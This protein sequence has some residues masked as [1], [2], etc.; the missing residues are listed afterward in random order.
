MF[1]ITVQLNDQGIVVLMWHYCDKLKPS[2]YGRDLRFLFF[3]LKRPQ[4]VIHHNKP[5][6]PDVC[7]YYLKSDLTAYWLNRA[8]GLLH[9]RGKTHHEPNWS[10]PAAQLPW[11]RLTLMNSEPTCVRMVPTYVKCST[12]VYVRHVIIFTLP[13]C[14][15]KN[16][17][18]D[19]ALRYY[20]GI[21]FTI[22]DLMRAQPHAMVFNVCRFFSSC[23]ERGG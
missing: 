5:Q 9:C 19:Q 8:L 18:G 11:R 15:P 23:T 22:H 17:D 12:A 13:N 16:Q 20:W 7:V 2:S 10:R 4:S 1:S 21:T 14:P 6:H 3:F